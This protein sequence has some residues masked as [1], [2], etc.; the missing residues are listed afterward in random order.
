MI[1]LATL[2]CIL[3][4]LILTPVVKKA[5]LRLGAVDQ[6]DHRKVHKQ[7]MPRLG[8][9]AIYVS[10]IIGLFLVVPH[11]STIIWILAGSL[12]IIVT[13]M[14]DDIKELSSKYKLIGQVAA[15]CLVIIGGL[16]IDFINL[17]FGGQLAFGFWSFPITLLW[18]VGMTNAINL[19]DG[20]DGLAAG[21]STIAL[22]TISF[23]AFLQGDPFVFAMA[24]ICIASTLGFL[25]YNFY[26]A[27]I[28]MGDTGAL[29]LGYIIAVLSLLGYKNV[30]FISFIIPII[31]LGVPI[32]DTIFAIIRRIIH[33]KPITSPDKA[34]LHHCLLNMGFSHRQAVLTIYSIAVMF[35]VAAILFSIT[36][37]WG[38]IMIIALVLISIEL[39]AEV[40]G[41]AGAEYRPL[42]SLMRRWQ[43]T[44]DRVK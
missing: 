26:P 31:I 7:T 30:T 39:F 37:L 35:S 4:S 9:L 2:I 18:L 38:S 13:G 20:L 19:I 27:K 25:F 21:V 41:L 36:T 12:I 15:A 17:P 43:L 23:M 11:H 32:S 22:V 24:I 28:F 5:A 3:A 42:I 14:I 8:G 6:P 16:D 29:F 10:F 44:N 40:L 33:K 1:L 34:H